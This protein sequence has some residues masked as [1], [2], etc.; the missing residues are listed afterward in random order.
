M[1]RKNDSNTKK[2][3][4][5][6]TPK[7]NWHVSEKAIYSRHRKNDKNW[8]YRAIGVH[9]KDMSRYQKHLITEHQVLK[10]IHRV[11]KKQTNIYGT[12]WYDKIAYHSYEDFKKIINIAKNV[13]NKFGFELIRSNYEQHFQYIKIKRVNNV[14]I[15][16]Y[17]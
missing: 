3:G 16:P 6:I 5:P 1:I 2:W 14:Y 9:Y 17:L 10:E 4:C 11:I 7:C 15:Y 13:A 12:V 8:G